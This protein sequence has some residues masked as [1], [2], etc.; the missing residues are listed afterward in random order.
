MHVFAAIFRLNSEGGGCN[1]HPG[2]PTSF[3]YIKYY[4]RSRFWNSP[5]M[6]IVPFLKKSDIA[7]DKI[8]RFEINLQI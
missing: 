4:Q 2:T 1:E 8:I 3:K 6:E 7:V 5:N